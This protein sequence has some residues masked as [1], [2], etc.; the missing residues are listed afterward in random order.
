MDKYKYLKNFDDNFLK[1]EA[2]N[3]THIL[4][5][6]NKFIGLRIDELNKQRHGIIKNDQISFFDLLPKFFEI[7]RE[8]LIYKNEIIVEAK[9]RK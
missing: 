2:D 4:E 3:V 8:L 7:R 6:L 9:S 5:V 1:L